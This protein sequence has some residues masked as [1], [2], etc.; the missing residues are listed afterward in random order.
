[1]ISHGTLRPKFNRNYR[2]KCS[3]QTDN[4]LIF[5]RIV[6]DWL[7]HFTSDIETEF[8]EQDS[9]AKLQAYVHSDWVKKNVT[10]HVASFTDVFIVKSFRDQLPYLCKRYFMDKWMHWV[11]DNSFT[12]SSNAHM[13]L[14]PISP[15][16]K[17]RIHIAGD[18]IVGHTERTLQRRASEA[19]TVANKSTKVPRNVEETPL[20]TA[21]RLLSP[22]IHPKLSDVARSEH[23]QSSKYRVAIKS[24][25]DNHDFDESDLCFLVKFSKNQDDTDKKKSGPGIRTIDVPE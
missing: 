11:A 24:G 14:D 23:L 2:L 8:E 1:M 12:E 25:D 3:V 6:Q 10:H 15:K 5:V 16:P 19:H 18:K 13:K 17:D 21:M 4:D 7:Y 9:L 20:D 22:Q